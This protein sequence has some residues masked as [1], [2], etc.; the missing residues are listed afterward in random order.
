MLEIREVYHPRQKQ[1][2]F[3]TFNSQS[4]TWLVSDLKSK[5]EIQKRLLGQGQT[6]VEDAVLRATELWRKFIMRTSPD[7]RVV[8]TD[9]ARS[10]LTQWL[11]EADFQWAKSPGAAQNLFAYTAQL[12]PILANEKGDD[13][14]KEWW[15]EHPDSLVRW[16][17]WYHLA[18]WAWERF[19]DQ[20]VLPAPWVSAWLINSS[21]Q[22]HWP[23]KLFVDLGSELSA[24]ES[25][26]IWSLSQNTEV[27]LLAPGAEWRGR[28]DKTM[29]GYRLLE[30][31][32]GVQTPAVKNPEIPR[33]GAYE[34][35]RYTTMLAEVKDATMMVRRWIEAGVSPAQIVLMAPEIEDYWPVLAEYLE[36]EGV[37]ANKDRV[38]TLQ[39]FPDVIRWLAHL[40]MDAGQGTS[41]DIELVA[42]ADRDSTPLK[43]A[44]FRRLFSAYY[45]LDDL[46]RD[47]QVARL[48]DL[49][50]NGRETLRR[51]EFVAWAIQRWPTGGA[52]QN[53]ETVFHQFFQD[54][55]HSTRLGLRHW[56]SLTEKVC[57][58]IEVKT[59]RGTPG[60]IQLLN[61]SSGEWVEA[62]HLWVLGLTEEGMRKTETTGILLSDV[63]SL[64]RDLGFYLHHPDRFQSEFEAE[65][66]LDRP[67]SEAVLSTPGVDFAGTIQTP[68]MLWLRRALELAKTW[69][70][71]SAPAETRWD[72]IQRAELR[73]LG[74]ARGWSQDLQE[75]VIRELPVE[76]GQTLA[77]GFGS[78]TDVS[79]SVSH[80]ES[81]L[82]CP[83]KVAAT[84]ILGLS[85]LPIIDMDV[86]HLSRGSLMHKLFEVL[87]RSEP[88]RS[89]YSKAELAEMVEMARRESQLLLA[90]E[91]LWPP[92]RQKLVDQASRFVDFEREWRSLFPKTKTV[93][94]EVRTQCRWNPTDLR[95]ES[96]EGSGVLFRGFIDRVDSDGEGNYVLLD[97][98]SSNHGL[99]YHRSWLSKHSLQLPLYAH[100]LALGFSSLGP[101]EVV[102]ALYYVAKNLDRTKGFVVDQGV[103]GLLGPAN[104]YQ[105][106]SLGDRDGLIKESVRILGEAVGAIL[107][108]N[109]GPRPERP[110]Q[111]CVTC[112]WRGLCRSPHLH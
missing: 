34:F 66:M 110:E 11:E 85:D 5:L 71:Y 26:L 7:V 17:Q 63:L 46:R 53:L 104:R 107:A 29:R 105:Q 22:L 92:L 52:T 64:E 78:L 83:F 16:G 101:G 109:L 106:V 112:Q 28:F 35:R 96:L 10:L 44:E 24:V 111:T 9:L 58:R 90:D 61:L 32:L 70:Q 23:R 108:G 49:K 100:W 57:A 97:Y 80:I 81:F 79:L 55:P 87:T 20:A 27:I 40:R 88:F 94:R 47:R 1:E 18:R 30:E 43:Y 33:S 99:T 31:R 45:D 12:L 48:F 73:D 84:K 39:S 76:L 13:L 65:W 68:T 6:L 51:D 15:S 86:D 3:G 21:E 36:C 37:P 42:F 4:D 102:G 59:A 56:V 19:A 77:A 91:R 8:S 72:Q 2:L 50:I 14:L 82:E 60:G 103:E 54:C 25:D 41:A 74:S 89:D 95:F 62:S 75:L 67:W 98:K 93:G 38:V 69:E